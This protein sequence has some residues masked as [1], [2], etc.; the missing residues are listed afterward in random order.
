MIALSIGSGIQTIQKWMVASIGVGDSLGFLLT[1]AICVAGASVFSVGLMTLVWRYRRVLLRGRNLRLDRFMAPGIPSINLFNALHIPVPKFSFDLSG[2]RGI[3]F[4][5]GVVAVGFALAFS[6]VIVATDDTPM[7]PEAGAVYALGSPDGTIGEPLPPDP[8][9]PDEQSHTLEVRL[10]DGTRLESL[11]VDLQMGK[12]S[13]TDCVGIERASG[14]GYLWVDEFS[15]DGFV[16]PTLAL[17]ASYIHQLTL[18]GDVDGHTTGPTQDSSGAPDITI[19]SLRGSSTYAATGRVDRLLIS[20][21]GDA[22]IKT[23]T[24]TGKCSIGGADLDFIKAGTVSLTNVKIGD[25]GDI[26]TAAVVIGNDTVVS[27]V[28]DNFTDKSIIVK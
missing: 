8:T 18:S 24:I 9:T 16:A 17:N 13:L 6:F 26:Q 22:Y 20:L 4:A 23:V 21:L 19:A 25:D 10:A 3:G 1:A 12:P 7:W 11:V 2:F 27:T 14:T 28:T 15:M 5:L